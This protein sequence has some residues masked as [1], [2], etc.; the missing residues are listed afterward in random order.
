MGY[1]TRD[2]LKQYVGDQITAPKWDLQIDAAIAAAS[3]AIDNHC[4]RTFVDAGSVSSRVFYPTSC[5]LIETQ[6]FS[7]TTGLVVKYDSGDDGTYETTI[8]STDYQVDPINGISAHGISG[9]P[10]TA[11]MLVGS[12]TVPTSGYRPSAQITARWGWAAVPADVAQACK[13]LAA[14]L[15][16]MKDAPHGVAGF[17]AE[18][19]AIRT[20]WPS[21]AI[22]L[23]RDY[24]L[25]GSAGLVVA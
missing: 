6:D 10:Y 20:R 5:R 21:T 9:W 17:G 2:E 12:T 16:T 7:T 11:I 18:G 3:R 25:A 23:L 13:V 15:F 14:H 8:A 1:V 22:E 24:R 19:F 4:G